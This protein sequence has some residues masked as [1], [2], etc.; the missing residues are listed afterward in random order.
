MKGETISF[1]VIL[2]TYAVAFISA[3][4]AGIYIQFLHPLIIVLICDVVA[5][6]VVYI[7]SSIYDNASLYDPY[8]SVGPIFIAFYFFI[9]N[10][11]SGSL[12]RKIW[13]LSLTFLWG[14][15]LTWNW[16]ENWQGLE[17][18][19][20]RYRMYR[21]NNPKL[22][23][24]VNLFGIQL[25]PT[26]LVYLGC[27]S[28]YPSL[29]ESGSYFSYLDVFAISITLLAIL[30]ESVADKQLKKFIEERESHKKIMKEGIWK[31]S[32]HPNYFGEILFWW[33]LYSFALASNLNFWWTIIGPISITLL[34]IFI[35]IP[36][37]DERN[38]NRRPQY[39]EYMEKTSKLVP[40]RKR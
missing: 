8:W 11:F 18:E 32:R 7:F 28:L 38:L 29:V 1:L 20:W 21:N 31:Y 26:I 17:D 12:I 36:L 19:D 13:V 22:F 14:M 35:S 39:K 30:V 37:M 16:A 25:M 10:P 2:L 5:T 23:W 27:L 34:F 40:W 33:G 24:L 15:R 4:L 9:I 6:L 3:F